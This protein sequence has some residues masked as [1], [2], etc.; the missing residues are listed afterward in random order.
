MTGMTRYA[1]TGYTGNTATG[2]SLP[3]RVVGQ[4]DTP[5]AAE[6]TV[7]KTV[8]YKYDVFDNL[9]EKTVDGAATGP[10]V[11]QYVYQGGDLVYE[12]TH[13]P[14]DPGTSD[15][16][17]AYTE[18]IRRL[19]APHSDQIL[20][21]DYAKDAAIDSNDVS[22][23]I[24]TLTD[25]QDSVTDIV[26]DTAG[27]AV[28]VATHIETD[29]FG[30]PSNAA[31]IPNYVETALR[32][33]RRYDTETGFYFDGD[34]WYDPAANRAISESTA[35]LLTEDPNAFRYDSNNPFGGGTYLNADQWASLN[36]A[37]N[38]LAGISLGVTGSVIAPALVPEIIAEGM[39]LANISAGAGFG[40]V[41]TAIANP[42]ASLGNYVFAGALGGLSGYLAPYSVYGG[43]AGTAA[44]AGIGYGFG[45]WRVGAQIGGLAGQIIGGGVQFGWRGAAFEASG[46][47]G[48]AGVGY[49]Y[50]HD[51]HGALAGAN[52]GSMAGALA[53]AGYSAY[54]LARN[55]SAEVSELYIH[56]WQGAWRGDV[57]SA[58]MGGRIWATPYSKAELARMSWFQR[59]WHV[60]RAGL[61]T[62]SARVTGDALDEFIRVRGIG[63]FRLAW[64]RA[65]GQY[66]SKGPGSIN[67]TTGVR[68]ADLGAR[69]RYVA[70]STGSYTMDGLLVGAAAGS[71]YAYAN[72]GWGSVCDVFFGN[73]G[74]VGD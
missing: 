20:A 13:Y 52:F 31:A 24:W 54:S 51:I 11:S 41:Q 15:T 55:M 57:A 64:K 34:R 66:F 58:G 23:F 36:F 5:I 32:A 61:P 67:L 19:F 65:G 68:T 72:G 7:E 14:D 47:F 50:T 70:M 43:I 27:S 17:E 73:S 38:L 42:D 21:I 74:V 46:A 60:G 9:I 44:G 1:V 71:V 59:I 53:H 40:M 33:G 48:G 6:V 10:V 45:D 29:V 25:G 49:A 2:M 3:G 26:I 18:T 30:V 28:V 62:D 56:T 37:S 22:Q 35:V 69:L 12:F 8:A 39:A 4:M 63:P 16:N